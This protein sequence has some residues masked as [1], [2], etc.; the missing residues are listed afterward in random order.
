[1]TAE[2][3][4]QI[5]RMDERITQILGWTQKQAE[6]VDPAPD[7]LELEKLEHEKCQSPD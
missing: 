5:G 2:V 4:A 7:P 3:K 1:M 6:G